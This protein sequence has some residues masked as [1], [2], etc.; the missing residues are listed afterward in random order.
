[1]FLEKDH[2]ENFKLFIIF[3]RHAW[4]MVMFSHQNAWSRIMVLIVCCAGHAGHKCAK[5]RH[6]LYTVS[7]SGGMNC[8]IIVSLCEYEVCATQRAGRVVST[9]FLW[10]VPQWPHQVQSSFIAQSQHW[11]CQDLGL[12]DE[13]LFAQY[14]ATSLVWS[15]ILW[16]LNSLVSGNR[17]LKICWHV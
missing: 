16:Q 7:T 6:C 5:I 4:W 15:C 3:I 11:G 13:C 10:T 2:D 8:L 17:S 14:L 1:M 12:W 9:L